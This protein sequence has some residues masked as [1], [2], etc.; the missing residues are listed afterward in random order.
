[1]GLSYSETRGVARVRPSLRFSAETAGRAPVLVA[2]ALF[3]GFWLQRALGSWRDLQTS[4]YDLAAFDQVIWNSAHGRLFETSF[5]P[6]NYVGE[7]FQPVLLL[8]VP[9]YW[10]GGGAPV[11]LVAQVLA[12]GIAAVVLYEAARTLRLHPAVSAAAAIAYLL[13][14]YLHR[15]LAFDFHPE[16]MLALPHSP[17]SGHSPADTCGSESD[18][19]SPSCSSRRT[20]YLSRSPS[21]Y[22]PRRSAI[23]ALPSRSRRS[24]SSRR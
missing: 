12:S 6:Y 22:A 11:L 9:F 3:I 7:H 16:T 17:R 8:F 14:P 19:H 10:P 13:N 18:A 24:R 4:A 5:L 20:P 15:A 2:V 21:P 1:M 23:D